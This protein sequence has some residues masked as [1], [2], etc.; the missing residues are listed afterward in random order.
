[1]ALA[2]KIFNFPQNTFKKSAEMP[3]MPGD[4]LFFIFLKTAPSSV[5]PSSVPTEF[6][7]C[8]LSL[9]GQSLLLD[10]SFQYCNLFILTDCGKILDIF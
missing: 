2:I 5:A 4:S 8:V 7:E 3:S 1:M 10:Y 6:W 9:H